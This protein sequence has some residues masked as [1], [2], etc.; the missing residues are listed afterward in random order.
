MGLGLRTVVQTKNG[1]NIALKFSGQMDTP[2]A[3]PVGYTFHRLVCQRNAES[4]LHVG[5]R[6]GKLDGSASRCRRAPLH[7]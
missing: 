2:L 6:A 7:S 1:N 5:D 3:N 4:P